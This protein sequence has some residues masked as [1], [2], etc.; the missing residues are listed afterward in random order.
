VAA[1]PEWYD[2]DGDGQLEAVISHRGNLS[3]WRFDGTSLWQQRLDN[4]LVS[5]VYDL[6]GDGESELVV[7]A[8]TPSQLHVLRARDGAVRYVVP[9]N[10]RWLASRVC[11]WPK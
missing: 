1:T 3:A 5:G 11:A 9:G 7:S 6:D 8:G 10:F 4:A 2:L